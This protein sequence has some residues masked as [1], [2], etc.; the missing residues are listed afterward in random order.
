MV[1]LPRTADVVIIG[2]GP[3]GTSALWALERLSPELNVVL[4]EKAPQL[5]SGASIASLEA[6]RSCWHTPV[7]AKQMERSLEVFFNADDYLGE[8]T[9]RKLAIHK[10]GYLFC[11]ATETQAQRLHN[12]VLHLHEIGVPAIEY[13]NA[14]EVQKRYKWVGQGV[15]G[16]KYDPNAGWL[17]SNALIQAFV[18]AAPKSQVIT[19]VKNVEI[20]VESGAVTGV[21][22]ADGTISSPRVLIAAG[23]ASYQVGLTAGVELPIRSIPR[24]S[25]TTGWRHDAFTTESPMII[26]PS[27]APHVRPEASSGAIF[28][29]EYH[30]N[31]KHSRED[32]SAPVSDSLKIPVD[33]INTLK[34]PRFPS[35]VLALMGRLLGHAPG[36]GFNAPRYLSGIHHN[37]GYYV[38]R[39][40]NAAYIPDENNERHPYESQRAIID[41]HPDVHGLF[42]SV[43]HVGHGIMTAP[44]AGEIAASLLAECELP[45]PLYKDLSFSTHWAAH[46]ESV[47]S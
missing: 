17:D 36:E 16:A 38:Y 11:A 30:W 23:A 26:A 6:F 31:S 46:D 5:G 29:W 19:D 14:D 27:P 43:A 20:V 33:N 3:A 8:G 24:Q 39:D 44:A 9:S 12:D 7:L 41:A 15:I 35:I 42:V 25:F 1:D 34:D 22:T 37:I 28:G 47:L 10:N 32:N 40:E 2:G 4:L 21:K 45:D 18:K 13:L